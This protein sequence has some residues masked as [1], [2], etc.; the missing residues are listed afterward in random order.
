[1]TSSSTAAFANGDKATTVTIQD[2]RK[3]ERLPITLPQV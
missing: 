3:M 1:M 2:P